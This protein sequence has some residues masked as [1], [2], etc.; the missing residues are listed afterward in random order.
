MSVTDVGGLLVSFIAL[1]IAV[2]GVLER[3]RAVYSS[4]RVR[5]TEIL[6]DVEEL[7][8]EEDKYV[9]GEFAKC[10]GENGQPPAALARYSLT[11]RRALLTYQAIALIHRLT[12]SRF[13]RSDEFHL[14][15]S[16][17]V[18]LATSLVRLGDVVGGRDQYEVA[19]ASTE[20]TTD[21]VRIAAHLGLAD[22]LFDLGQPEEGRRHFAEAVRLHS[23][24]EIGRQMAFGVCINRWLSRELE[25]GDDGEPALAVHA[26]RE[27]VERAAAVSQPPAWALDGQMAL[28][29]RAT[30]TIYVNGEYA[31][32]I[33]GYEDDVPA[34][35]EP[36]AS[37]TSPRLPRTGG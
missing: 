3:Q 2:Y 7:N 36:P 34:S 12:R 18:S 10:D 28:R 6:G 9:E 1:G 25:A 21:R 11:G 33:V 26:G 23:P 29:H 27:I 4:V 5:I 31:E 16:E 37:L 22:C 13:G 35:V 32:E 24:D 15:P 19:L 17:Y 20:E 14:T 8:V 30:R